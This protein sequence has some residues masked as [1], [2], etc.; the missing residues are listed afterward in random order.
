MF[1]RES[2][3]D[4]KRLLLDP[5]LLSQDGTVALT[6]WEVSKDGRYLAYA[7]STSGSDWQ[8]WRIRDVE[9]GQDLPD[10]IEWS[11][12]S[13]AAWLP[14]SSGFF[15]SR[16]EAPEAGKAYEEANYNQK[17]FFHKLGT[18]QSE[19]RLVYERPDQKEWGF[20]A[21]VSDNGKYLALH[22]WQG[23]D[24]RNRFFYQDLESGE[25]IIE[26]IPEL[27]ATYQFIDHDGPLF[28][29][30]TD[31]DAPR[32]RVIAIDIRTPE[33]ANWRTIIPESSDVL[34]NIIVANQQFVTIYLHNAYHQL[35]R[36]KM[37]GAIPWRDSIASDG[38]D[39]QHQL[40]F[41]PEWQSG[42]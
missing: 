26:L 40:R 28:Y 13:G 11:K 36:F 19:D 32:G 20:D 27:E 15:Y 14:D 3:T 7:T 31:L 38:I 8:T 4:E 2:L 6:S 35:K 22:V 10:V 29:F 12:F 16:Y 1:T 5:N 25:E 23:T 30:R 41:E 39:R 24:I 37:S 42:R 21:R 18:S 17:L 34:E 9:T 33:K